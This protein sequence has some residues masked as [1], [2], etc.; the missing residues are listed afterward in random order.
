MT[1]ASWPPW[2]AVGAIPSSGPTTLTFRSLREA[3]ALGAEAGAVHDDARRVVLPARV[4]GA[5][6]LVAERRAAA[7]R[8]RAAAPWRPL[9]LARPRASRAR[10]SFGIARGD[11]GLRA[12]GAGASRLAAASCF[13]G[14]DAAR[15]RVPLER[16]RER[17]REQ[18]RPPP[19]ISS[20][21]SIAATRARDERGRAPGAEQLVRGDRTG[22]PRRAGGSAV[23]RRL[24]RPRQRASDAVDP[25]PGARGARRRAASAARQPSS[26]SA[27][28]TSSTERRTSPRRG[29]SNA[30]SALAARDR[31]AARGAGRARSSRGRCRR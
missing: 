30:G 4:R 7:P 17:L 11:R 16:V 8:P 12:D 29:G 19:P 22:P 5:G 25:V 21:S 3:Q 27:R 13:A 23:R 31:G 18:E 14:A 15:L 1:T 2:S 6:D 26:R 28:E 20:T 10:A 24:L 9:P